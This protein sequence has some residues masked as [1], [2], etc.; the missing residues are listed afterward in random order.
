MIKDYKEHFKKVR[1]NRTHWNTSG[2]FENYQ[3]KKHEVSGEA[4]KQLD[5]LK[6]LLMQA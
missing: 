2:A 1:H 5:D 3:F 6:M 4:M